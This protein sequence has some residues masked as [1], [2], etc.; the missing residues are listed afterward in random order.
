MGKTGIPNTVKRE[1]SKL[2]TAYGNQG[3][4]FHPVTYHVLRISAV[5]FLAERMNDG[6]WKIFTFVN[7]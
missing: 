3:G 2:I 7:Q 6:S 4:S 5:A 1:L